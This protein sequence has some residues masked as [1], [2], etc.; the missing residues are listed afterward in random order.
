MRERS[1]PVATHLPQLFAPSGTPRPIIDQIAKATRTVVAER[2]YQQVLIE[3]GFEPTLDST[4]EK[5]RP[6]LA[7]DI[8]LWKPIVKALALKID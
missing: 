2:T 1:D 7:D 3:G 6:M 4:P 8:S 5:F